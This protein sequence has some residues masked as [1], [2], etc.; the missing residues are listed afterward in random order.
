MAVVIALCPSRFRKT[1]K[2]ARGTHLSR[3][4]ELRYNIGGGHTPARFRDLSIRL[5][6]M[7]PQPGAIPH[8][9]QGHRIIMQSL[10]VAHRCEQ[11]VGLMRI[12]P[13]QARQIIHKARVRQ[14]RRDRLH[15]V[16]IPLSCPIPVQIDPGNRGVRMSIGHQRV[17][18][19]RSPIMERVQSRNTHQFPATMV[20]DSTPYRVKFRHGSQDST[21]LPKRTSS[22]FRK[23]RAGYRMKIHKPVRQEPLP[24]FDVLPRTP[25]SKFDLARTLS[26]RLRR[27]CTKQLR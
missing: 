5:V 23:P 7:P 24:I 4:A 15:G 2:N 16:H 18:S 20:S 9:P 25:S 1:R 21:K 22:G 12:L 27:R 26:C 19:H 13:Q 8:D 17:P 6:V 10:I 11:I 3:V 14:L